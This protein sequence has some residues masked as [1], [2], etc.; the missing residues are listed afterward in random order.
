[1][2]ALEIDRGTTWIAKA[3][4]RISAEM[5]KSGVKVGE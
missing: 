1:L 5:G 2:A 3:R 4:A